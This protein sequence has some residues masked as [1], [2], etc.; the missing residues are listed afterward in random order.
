[1]TLLFRVN[2]LA[3][4][5][6]SALVSNPLTFVPQYYLAWK[7]GSILL[8][9]RLDWKQL[10]GVLLLVRHASFFDGIKIMGNLGV[11]ALLVLLT[12]GLVLAIPVGIITYLITL[13]L[14]TRLQE[15]DSTNTC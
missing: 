7:I 12:G 6:M 9:G 3:A 14:F 4:L 10:H 1:M 2:T 15:K 8:P 11:D 13:R 5:L